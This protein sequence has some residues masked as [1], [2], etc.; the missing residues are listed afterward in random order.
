MTIEELVKALNLEG[1]D[2]KEKVEILKK[3]FKEKENE[4]N[5]VSKQLKALEKENEKFKADAETNNPLIDKFNIA[6]KAFGFD[7]EAEDFDKML[8]EVKDKLAKDAGNGVTPEEVKALKRDL[9]KANR[10]LEKS[11]AELKTVTEQL[12]AEKTTRITAMKRDA[13][14]K[15]LESVNALNPSM[16][17]DLFLNKVDVDKDG[18][19]LTMKD[20]AGNDISVA[21]GIADW[22]KENT[23]LVKKTVK[24][25]MGSG[26]SNGTGSDGISEFVKGMIASRT[27]S[28]NTPEATKSLAEVF[29]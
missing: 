16:F 10:D 15:E 17:V 23:D 6:A 19:T 27:N 28:G 24:G 29:G 4:F 1:D 5:E 25:G 20:A 12:E 8:D 21:D 22:A 11:Q 13:I 18:K 7:L 3:E 14:K 2:S 26:G 9:T